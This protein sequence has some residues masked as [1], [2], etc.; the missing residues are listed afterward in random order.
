MEGQREVKSTL[1]WNR[2]TGLEIGKLEFMIG[3]N[4]HYAIDNAELETAERLMEL[5]D[6]NFDT[7]LERSNGIIDHIMSLAKTKED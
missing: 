7:S 1:R 2:L 5:F 4:D 3:V 6:D